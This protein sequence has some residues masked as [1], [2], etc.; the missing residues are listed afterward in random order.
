[1]TSRQVSPPFGGKGGS[2]PVCVCSQVRC[3][4]RSR[5]RER[6]GTTVAIY[7]TAIPSPR[8]KKCAQAVVELFARRKRSQASLGCEPVFCLGWGEG[9]G[10]KAEN[11]GAAQSGG[12]VF[13][14]GTHYDSNAK[15]KTHRGIHAQMQQARVP[16]SLSP[17][18]CYTASCVSAAP[19]SVSLA[20]SLSG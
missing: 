12:R 11:T 5:S 18:A 4:R 17:D 7:T 6:I 8:T 14:V 10:E 9:G 3:A 1:M 13:R 19:L 20:H 15:V 16:T 2:L